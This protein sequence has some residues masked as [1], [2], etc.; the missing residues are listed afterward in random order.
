MKS[1]LS[2]GAATSEPARDPDRY[3]KPVRRF[4]SMTEFLEHRDF[5]PSIVQVACDDSLLEFLLLP[6]PSDTPLIVNYHAALSGHAYTLPYFT[7]LNITDGIRA[8]QVCFSDPSLMLDADLKL[9]WYAGHRSLRLQEVWPLVL[10]H[11]GRCFGSS[12]EIHFGSSGGGFAALYY[13]HNRPRAMA[14]TVNP[15]TSLRRYLPGSVRNYLRTAW[16]VPDDVGLDEG[17]DLTGAVHD[18]NELYG[19]GHSN[20]VVYI[21]NSEDDH[22]T[23]HLIPFLEAT[24]GSSRPESVHVHLHRWGD[25][26]V[27][28][29]SEFLKIVLRTMAR[30]TWQ[31]T[32]EE[33]NYRQLPHPADIRSALP[34]EKGKTAST[35]D[36]KR[37][38]PTP[39]AQ[40][41]L[42]PHDLEDLDRSWSW[43][44]FPHLDV[45]A[46][47]R[48]LR[49]FALNEDDHIFATMCAT[50]TFYEHG[51]LRF[52]EA[53]LEPDDLVVDVGANIGNHTAYF[54]G[55][56]GCTVRAFEAVPVLADVLALTVRANFLDSRVQL[57]PYAVGHRAGSIGVAS[58]NPTNSG[59][60]RL[61]ADGIGSIPMVALDELHWPQPPR[62]I[63]IDVEGMELDVLQGAASVVDQYRPLLVVEAV[64][65]KADA[66]IR[67]WM[68][69]HGYA[70]LGVFN[71]TPT[72][73]CTPVAGTA[74]RTPDEIVYR[75]LEHLGERIN[76][77]QVRLDRFGRYV[78]Q[79]QVAVE[80]SLEHASGPSTSGPIRTKE[81]SVDPVVRTLQ[82][83]NMDLRA[84]L[85]A[86]EKSVRTSG[87][88]MSE[89]DSV[90][91]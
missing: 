70:V 66:A 57:E 24:H 31:Q 29:T 4:D 22:A 82:L 52:L 23:G 2:S 16:G 10:D 19:H 85:D 79:V 48:A 41:Q 91:E 56:L 28:P 53:F 58:W 18:L 84:K 11:L 69:Q 20:S 36:Q 34:R 26:H 49:I 61:R 75:V 65:A 40:G 32:L 7:G 72:L 44:E 59:A 38:I 47:D 43:D 25:G 35:R 63:K 6:G 87:T 42:R 81:D 78:H 76:D 90:H 12:R 39:G 33:G 13:A 45:P 3:G 1:E 60:T 68:E 14:I 83:Q 62:V 71:A 88:T 17:L 30:P 46:G 54:A 21:Q 89:K 64:D 5:G 15:Q 73:V 80:N 8:T 55:V 74:R 27:P 37:S 51:L 9:A 50:G 77:L 86:L 67:A